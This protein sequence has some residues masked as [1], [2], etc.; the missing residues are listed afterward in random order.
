MHPTFGVIHCTKCRAKDEPVR[1]APRF[2]TLTMQD[3]ITSQQDKHLG[4]LAQ[5]WDERGK[6]NKTFIQANPDAVKDYFTP[7]QLKEL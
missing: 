1:E 7:D 3:R 5:P 6:P 2:A 4:A